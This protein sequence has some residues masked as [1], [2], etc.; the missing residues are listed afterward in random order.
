LK[1]D[2]SSSNTST[3]GGG[4]HEEHRS[5]VVEEIDHDGDHP[6]TRQEI[7]EPIPNPA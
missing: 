7:S 1:I 6:V 5:F 3:L 2:A 4:E